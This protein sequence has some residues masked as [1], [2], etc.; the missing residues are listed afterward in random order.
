MKRKVVVAVVIVAVLLAATAVAVFGFW[1]PYRNAKSTMATGQM[2][3]R[4][5]DDGKLQLTWPQSDTKDRYL[6]EIREAGNGE[7]PYV[8]Y[9]VY[10]T[11]NTWTL[12]PLPTDKELT[13][14]L[15][16]VVDYAQLWM[17]KERVS[18][19]ELAVSA[20][21]APP[22][23]QDMQWVADEEANTVTLTYSLQD[24][25]WCRLYWRDQTG[26]WQEVQDTDQTTVLFA[27]G[28]KGEFPVP[29]FG[30]KIFFQA[31]VYRMDASLVFYG[32]ISYGFTVER[33]DLLGR[34]LNP[35]ITDE[36]YNVSTITWEETKGQLYQVQ[37]LNNSGEWEVLTA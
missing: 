5:L 12:P 23:L 16:T 34:D 25:E 2:E 1:L 37:R 14:S 10:T 18:E 29:S 20:I 13:I 27:F 11:E 24:D 22:V 26:Q 9:R 35:V 30:E 19:N 31:D 15:R 17:N 6:L 28:D 4:E 3:L 21:L 7:N 32:N 33:D 36:G 8:Y